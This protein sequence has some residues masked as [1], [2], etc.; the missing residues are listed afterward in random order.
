M[1]SL[2]V[3]YQ[4]PGDSDWN[5]TCRLFSDPVKRV[6]RRFN[7][8]DF[9]KFDAFISVLELLLARGDARF[10]NDVGEPTA[11][12]P[13]LPV[14]TVK[15]L[16]E[17]TD[18]LKQQIRIVGPDGKLDQKPE[19]GVQSVRLVRA[20]RESRFEADLPKSLQ[21]FIGLLDAQADGAGIE[22][23]CAPQVSIRAAQAI[24][25]PGNLDLSCDA[26]GR[27][28]R[29]ERLAFSKEEIESLRQA[30]QDPPSS[31][32]NPDSNPICQEAL[33]RLFS[34]QTQTKNN[35]DDG[36]ALKLRVTLTLRSV[37]GALYY[38]GEL[39]R[40][41]LTPNPNLRVTRQA[42]G[43][44]GGLRLPADDISEDAD[45]PCLSRDTAR[46]AGFNRRL[47]VLREG[48]APS[49]LSVDFRGVTYN[50]PP[51]AEAGRS[52]QLLALIKQ[53][54][55][56]NLKSTEEPTTQVVRFLD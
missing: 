46:A 30:L 50:V 27:L 36:D 21:L 43:I 54:F 31:P 14:S 53:I 3:E 23:L 12:T 38:L 17:V 11:L 22:E 45:T 4:R 1:E 32:I 52:L 20:S 26:I 9:A 15:S 8:D 5:T 19:S 33:T 55:A 28:V 42:C 41:Q 29:G 49:A 51:G 56:L 35:S 6:E 37:Q 2:T 7:D 24:L 25:D 10:L 18:L 39:A 40:A 13:A 34:F 16:T 44:D 47:F 48:L